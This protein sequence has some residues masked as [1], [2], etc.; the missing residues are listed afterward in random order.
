MDTIRGKIEALQI[1]DGI[2]RG[3]E[4]AALKKLVSEELRVLDEIVKLR[5]H[6][7][8][9]AS[10]ASIA[11]NFARMAGDPTIPRVMLFSSAPSVAIAQGAMVDVDFR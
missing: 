11:F 6:H 1:E 8:E 9:N 5:S 10:I 2:C 7:S 4:F 3:M